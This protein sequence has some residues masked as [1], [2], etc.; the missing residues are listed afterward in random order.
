MIIIGLYLNKLLGVCGSML[1]IL[2][3]QNI[4]L[5]RQFESVIWGKT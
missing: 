2:P 5:Q 1:L 4:A 3:P